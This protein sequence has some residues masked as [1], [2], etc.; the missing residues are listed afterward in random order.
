MTELKLKNY[1]LRPL[2]KVLDYPKNF[3]QSR[4]LSKFLDVL[5]PQVKMIED[6]RQ[7]IIKSL[8]INDDKNKPVIENDQYVFTPENR[9]IFNKEFFDLQNEDFTVIFPDDNVINS[10]IHMINSSPAEL[11]QQ[12]A[13]VV[14]EIVDLLSNNNNNDNHDTENNKDA[15]EAGN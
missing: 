13:M 9:E 10:V 14:S 7:K 4:S 6:S 3:A 1:Q 8:C 11:I 15:E 5:N 2:Y 12:E